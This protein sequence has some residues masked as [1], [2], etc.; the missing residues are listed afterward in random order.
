MLDLIRSLERPVPFESRDI[1]VYV[2]VGVARYWRG[3]ADLSALPTVHG[4][5]YGRPGTAGKEMA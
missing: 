3:S 1:D 5:R 2:S 4:R